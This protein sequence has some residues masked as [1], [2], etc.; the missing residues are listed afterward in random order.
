MAKIIISYRRQDSEAITGRIRDR[1]VKQ[2]GDDSIFMDIDSIPFGV[3]FR[4]HIGEAL[5]ET[6]ML[7]AVMGPKWTG[8]HKGGR[9]RIREENDPVRIE[10]EKAL[11]RRIPVIPILVNSATMPKTDEL[12][13]RLKEL[14]Y[15]NAATVDS[16]RDFHQHMDRLIRSIDQILASRIKQP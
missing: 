14:S 2:Y 10:V 9:S 15:R 12:P 13:E 1:L 3:D 7:V 11:E 5:R 16:G 4:D 8:I 6:D